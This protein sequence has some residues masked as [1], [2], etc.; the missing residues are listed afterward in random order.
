MRRP[1]YWQCERMERAEA[2]MRR[3]FVDL[4]HGQVHWRGGGAD[5]GVPLLLLHKAPFAAATLLPLMHR[6][7]TTRPVLAPD[8][9]GCGDSEPLPMPAPTIADFAD[10]MLRVLDARGLEQVDVYGTHSGARIAAHLAV[11]H[12]GRVRRVVLDGFGLTPMTDEAA[13]ARHAPDVLLDTQGAA[14]IWLWHFVR[15]QH[16]FAP[17]YARDAAHRRPRGLPDAETLHARFVET[18]KAATTW[19]H[20]YR[21]ALRYDMAQATPRIAQPLM[22]LYA[23]DDSVFAQFEAARA[24]LPHATAHATDGHETPQAADATAAL[25]EDFLTQQ[26]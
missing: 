23:R 8:L 15:D 7:G 24:L 18:A 17:W 14:M 26:G 21:A 11:H 12:P 2:A 13:I 4:P 6:L 5:H 10:A 3:G 1:P 19:Q 22:L 16:V 9:P 25:I 20:L